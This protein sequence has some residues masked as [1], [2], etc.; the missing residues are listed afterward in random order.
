MKKII[1]YLVGIIISVILVIVS[2]TI[3]GNTQILAPVLIVF[4]IYLFIGCL[5]KLCKMNGKL[6]DTIICTIDLL[7]WL[8][9]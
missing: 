3:L 1:P 8:S 5:I 2:M 6:K 4:D 9:W 7:W